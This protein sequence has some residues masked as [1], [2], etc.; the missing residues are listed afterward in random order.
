MIKGQRVA[1]QFFCL[2]GLVGLLESGLVFMVNYPT[3]RHF[4]E[5]LLATVFSAPLVTYLIGGA[6][7]I[8]GV[9]TIMSY[10]VA[11]RQHNQLTKRLAALTAGQ[12]EAP[13][14]A[15]QG[16]ATTLLGADVADMLEALRQKMIRLQREIERYSNTPV[17]VAGETKEE[18]LTQER[19]RLARELHDSVSQQLFAAM[20]ML[21]ALR[22]VMSQQS[23][24]D[25]Q[26]KQL[27]TIE[28]VINEAQAE[29]RALLLHLRPTTLEGKSLRDGIIALLQ[30]L[31]TKIKIEISWELADVQLGAAIEDNL[32]RIV[33]ELLSNTLRHAKA[34]SLEVY[35]K[36]V[37]NHVVLRVIDDGVGFDPQTENT[38]GS[39]GLSNIQERAA[40]LGGTA[41]VI[42]FPNQGT[43]VEVR[44][45]ITKEVADD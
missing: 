41:K 20:M 45:P 17:L 2:F 11:R 22:S 7:V 10:G 23:P 5:T 30:E 34:H 29:M 32:F 33:Q 8:A 15:R 3:K 31:Q 24:D 1:W 44:V 27:T 42:S 36:P 14:L 26:L 38:T 4:G 9:A 40:S 35:L 12:M 28:G 16:Q 21:S 37:A 18:I 6:I 43:S 13:I 19:H 25:P 39:Y